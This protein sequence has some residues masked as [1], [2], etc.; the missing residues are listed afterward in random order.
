MCK[1]V[2]IHFASSLEAV[3]DF[4]LNQFSDTD[5]YSEEH[6]YS[7]SKLVLLMVEVLGTSVPSSFVQQVLAV[8]SPILQFRYSASSRVSQ[9]LL[10]PL[11]VWTPVFALNLV[12]VVKLFNEII[13]DHVWCQKYPIIGGGI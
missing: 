1:G 5:T 9:L 4:V 11:Q 7:A 12:A 10:T 2:E 8:D 13:S 6:T 3:L